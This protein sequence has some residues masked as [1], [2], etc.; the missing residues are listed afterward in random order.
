MASAATS[1]SLASLGKRVAVVIPARIGSTRLTA[2]PLAMLGGAPMIARVIERAAR[3]RAPHTVI[4]ATDSDAVADAARSAGATPVLTRPELRSGTDRVHAAVEKMGNLDAD[5]IINVQGDEPLVDPD[6]I[7]RA[8][9]LLLDDEAADMSTLSAPLAPKWLL[10]ASK[11]KVVSRPLASAPSSMA[12]RALFFS[13]APIG[14]EREALSTMLREGD[15]RG[16]TATRYACRLHVGIYGF[17]RPALS[18]FVGLP[19]SP[20][21][22]LEGLE[23]MRALSAGMTIAVG[24][25]ERAFAGVDTAADLAAAIAHFDRLAECGD[26]E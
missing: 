19:P 5:I 23:Q 17:R 18:R 10:D 8:V 26:K 11:V 22:E 1:A 21:E 3:A 6:A 16:G 14:V 13:R 9:Q 25:V 20:L 12:S 2:K 15:Q 4:V 24:E 7:D